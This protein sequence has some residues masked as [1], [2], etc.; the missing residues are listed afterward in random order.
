[1]PPLRR[2][3]N[4]PLARRHAPQARIVFDTIDLHY[5]RERRGAELAGDAPWPA[6]PNARAHSNSTSSRA[7]TPPWS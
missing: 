2:L 5:L 1:V 6:P 3:G 7:A 4:A